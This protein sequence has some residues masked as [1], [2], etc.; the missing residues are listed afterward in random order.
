M[1]INLLNKVY[2]SWIENNNINEFCSAEELMYSDEIKTD[3]Q[4]EWLKR[5]IHIWNKC[6][7]LS[8]ER[9]HNEYI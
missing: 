5:F 9:K 6:E 4:K 3:E 8:Y 7:D 1:T 2:D